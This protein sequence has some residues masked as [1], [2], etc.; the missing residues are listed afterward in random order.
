VNVAGELM[1]TGV[2][3]RYAHSREAYLA[4]V[5]RHGEKV[6]T[7]PN[8]YIADFVPNPGGVKGGAMSANSII[9][10]T[11]SKEAFTASPAPASRRSSSRGPRGRM[12]GLRA[13]IA[14]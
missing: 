12:C 9:R 4:C 6:A 14:P 1:A 8:F 5:E 2:G 10:A 11:A 13:A 7:R 3:A